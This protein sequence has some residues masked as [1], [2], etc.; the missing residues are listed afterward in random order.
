MSRIECEHCG[1]VI[2]N[3]AARFCEFCGTEVVREGVPRSQTRDETRKMRFG[4]LEQHAD[5]QRLLQASP[6]GE[7]P[8]SGAALFWIAPFFLG[9]LV[10]WMTMASKMNAPGFMFLV[11]IFMLGVLG[12]GLFKTATTTSRV[13]S[14]PLLRNTAIVVDERTEVS[15]GGKNSRTRTSYFATLEFADGKRE[16]YSIGPRL[17]G[18]LSPGDAGVAYTK[19]DHLNAFERLSV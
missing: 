3:Q 2:K 19:S 18:Q 16:E 12:F 14:A 9:F 1:G 6:K 7:G 8:Q 17:A 15:G 10:F 5:L 4:M 11:P 13:R